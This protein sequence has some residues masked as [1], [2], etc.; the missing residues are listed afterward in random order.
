MFIYGEHPGISEPSTG[1][2]LCPSKLFYRRTAVNTKVW[3][4]GATF[5]LSALLFGC[6]DAASQDA[7]VHPAKQVYAD[8]QSWPATAPGDVRLANFTPFRAVY[9][10]HYRDHN[11]EHRQDRV[12][13]T[14]EHVAWGAEPAITVSLIDTGSLDYTDTTARKQTRFFGADD[15][16][17]LL[18]ITPSPGAAKDYDLIV[19]EAEEIYMTRVTTNTGEA[20]HREMPLTAPGF[21][22]PGA[23]VAG[24]MDLETGMRLRLDPYY[25]APS[26]G[27][28][29][30]SPSQVT[31]QEWIEM[32]DGER[33]QAWMVEYPLGMSNARMMRTF[34]VDRPPYLLAK[35]PYDLDGGEVDEVGVLRLIEF[36]AFDGG[37]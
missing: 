12:I 35:Q 20:E 6:K 21:G 4:V 14:A 15:L 9:E 30:T 34:V 28:L 19:A 31:G 24:S 3:S 29:G 37:R 10:R 26:S 17:I 16:R 8:A 5:I 36:Q 1:D 32:P 33:Q 18:Q 13:V 2:P 7:D 22:A 27:V 25:A 11:G 23:W